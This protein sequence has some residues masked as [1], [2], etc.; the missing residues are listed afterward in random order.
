MADPI[1]GNRIEIAELTPEPKPDRNRRINARAK[2]DRN[3]RINIGTKPDQHRRNT[4]RINKK[5]NK[6]RMTAPPIQ[7][8]HPVNSEAA[9]RK[10][11]RCIKAK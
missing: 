5:A 7:M 4:P 2:P 9:P 3:R 10:A 6:P 1:A 8:I 11:W